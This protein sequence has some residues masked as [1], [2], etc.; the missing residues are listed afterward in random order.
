MALA[1]ANSWRGRT[2]PFGSGVAR[3]LGEGVPHREALQLLH[4]GVGQVLGWT[5][6]APL[7]ALPALSRRRP[8]P[9]LGA[10]EGLLRAASMG[11][12]I[13]ST[14]LTS[15]KLPVGGPGPPLGP[16][17]C[18]SCE[19]AWAAN[20]AAFSAWWGGG[21]SGVWLQDAW[22]RGRKGSNWDGL[23]Q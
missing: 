21:Y 22:L 5:P 3:G 15:P 6:P 19:A 7:P 14:R 2:E 8:P 11:A 10:E 4:G 16:S 17:G 12:S 13:D 1:H 9:L 18:S 20:L 23:S